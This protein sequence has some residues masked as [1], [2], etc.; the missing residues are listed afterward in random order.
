MSFTLLHVFVQANG[1]GFVPF[2]RPGISRQGKGVPLDNRRHEAS[3]IGKLRIESL[4]CL[5]DL[6]DQALPDVVEITGIK[7][8]LAAQTPGFPID[9]PS[10]KLIDAAVGIRWKWHCLH[11]GPNAADEQARQAATFA[12]V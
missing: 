8:R 4:A 7:P 12:V 2:C 10:C 9:Q 11:L 5:D 1:A 6:H 3:P